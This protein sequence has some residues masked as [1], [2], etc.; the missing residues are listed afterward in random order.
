VPG[1]Q[2][3]V[4]V[5]AFGTASIGL[6]VEGNS[7]SANKGDHVQVLSG[8]GA[9]G[10]GTF[11][12]ATIRHNTMTGGASGALGQGITVSAAGEAPL[13]SGSLKY[14]I[15][16][17]SVNGAISYALTVDL[18]RSGAGGLMSGFVRNNSIGT[19]GVA[20]SCSA[21]ADGL[22]L[23]AQ[24]SGTHTVSITGNTI[25]RCFDRGISLA[26]GDGN[27][28]LN[29][30]VTSNT[31]TELADTNAGQGTPRQA[32]IGQFGTTS[33]N[34][35]GG[36]DSST[37]C[38]SLSGNAFT[39]GAFK[40]GDIRLRQRFRNRVVQ[41]GYAGTAFDDTAVQAHLVLNNVGST[42]AVTH[43]D[44]AG[45]TTEG[46]FGGGSCALPTP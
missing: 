29:A 30:T 22:F 6:T 37:T 11:T 17:N 38:L 15:D 24:G 10:S 12:A 42:A 9:G 43:V 33:T 36:V 40:D 25:R 18:G 13:W 26:T 3:G 45:S 27:G 14:D 41:P 32:F 31:V 44:D 23:D 21:Q 2:D 8:N 4:Q 28:N 16:G 7:F 5:A 35:L 39:G 46:Y 20:L 34:I 1:T 19:I